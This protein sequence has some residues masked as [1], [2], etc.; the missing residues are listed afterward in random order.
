MR[1]RALVLGSISVDLI[2]L[3]IAGGFA[4]V[5]RHYFQTEREPDPLGVLGYYMAVVTAAPAALSLLLLAMAASR[6]PKWRSILNGLA[7]A[8]AMIAAGWLL[9]L[10]LMYLL[11]A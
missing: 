11:P 1:R 8:L 6:R 10:G 4:L 2:A 3:L 7:A 9:L 5:T